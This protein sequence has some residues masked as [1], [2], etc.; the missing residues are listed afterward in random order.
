MKGITS[1]HS[2][3]GINMIVEGQGGGIGGYRGPWK[4]IKNYKKI[5]E[6]IQISISSSLSFCPVLSEIFLITPWGGSPLQFPLLIA[7]DGK[8]QFQKV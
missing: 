5:I 6:F 2:A 4:V 1:A 7:L 8:F 3:L